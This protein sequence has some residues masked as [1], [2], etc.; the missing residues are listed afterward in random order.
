MTVSYRK[1][2]SAG[3]SY[4][5]S[6][7][8]DRPLSAALP[9]ELQVDPSWCV[10][11]PTRAQTMDRLTL[12]EGLWN[13]SEDRDRFTAMA[14]GFSLSPS[15]LRTALVRNTGSATRVALHDFTLSA[16]KSV[17][18]VWAFSAPEERIRIEQAQAAAARAFIE[19]MSSNAYSRQG[20]GGRHHSSCAVVVALFP[21]SLSRRDDPQLHTHCTFLNIA[22][23]LDGSTGSMETLGMMRNLG[24]A[25]TAYHDELATG[26]QLL[27]FG[28][29][30]RGGLFEIDGVSGEVCTAFSLRRREALTFAREQYDPDR[31]GGLINDWRPSRRLMKQAVLRTRPKKRIQVLSDL[32]SRWLRRAAELGFE[33]ASVVPLRRIEQNAPPDIQPHLAWGVDSQAN[34]EREGSSG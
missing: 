15:G 4:Y 16:P 18:V 24:Q 14:N 32:R 19:V 5:L 3:I 30:R 10:T 7:Q 31:S 25:A 11:G 23:R 27:G 6:P 29:R 33:P 1:V 9:T 20:R 13:C 21:H 28:V 26:I 2:R 8:D 17:S 22:V 34:R 12:S